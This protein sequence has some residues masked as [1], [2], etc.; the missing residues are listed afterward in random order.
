[1]TSLP[2]ELDGSGNLSLPSCLNYVLENGAA[3]HVKGKWGKSERYVVIIKVKKYVYTGGN[4]FNKTLEN[5]IKALCIS[6]S[7][8]TLNKNKILIVLTLA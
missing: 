8:K 2:Q 4:T 1:M 6:M 3:Q 5:R 7:K